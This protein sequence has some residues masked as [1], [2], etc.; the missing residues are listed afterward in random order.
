MVRTHIG[1][2]SPNKQDTA[3]AHGTA[4]GE[5]EIKLTKKNYGWDPEK[6]FFIPDEALAMFRKAVEE[7][8]KKEDAW[9]KIFTEYKIQNPELAT[10]L[11]NI[12]KGNFGEAWKKALPN[13]YR[14]NGNA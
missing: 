1:F 12:R 11:E 8:R 4:L 2:G 9:Q 13:I 10:E 5:E 3:E 6:Q 7:G 14:C